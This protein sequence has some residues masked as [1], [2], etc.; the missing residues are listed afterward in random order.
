MTGVLY[1][2]KDAVSS[3]MTKC[4][5]R[6]KICLLTITKAAIFPLSE[7]FNW[8][9]TSSKKREDFTDCRG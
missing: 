3:G 9:K 1:N 6:A 7:P 8:G 4:Q 5:R 2:S